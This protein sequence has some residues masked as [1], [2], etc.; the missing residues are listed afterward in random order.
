MPAR[1]QT[2]VSTGN[3]I[4][5]LRIVEP[6]GAY[7]IGDT[8]TVSSEPAADPSTF[9]VVTVDDIYNNIGDSLELSGFANERM[10][11][12]SRSSMFLVQI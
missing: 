7:G 5:S 1:N 3:T 10:N 4:S 8:M 12:V 9:A 11:G 6:G 2:N